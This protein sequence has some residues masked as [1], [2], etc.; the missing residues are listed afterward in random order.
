MPNI[1]P[2]DRSDAQV[3][4]GAIPEQMRSLEYQRLIMERG[5]LGKRAYML[6]M[7]EQQ[8][9]PVRLRLKRLI[10]DVIRAIKPPRHLASVTNFKE[11]NE[12]RSRK[13]NTGFR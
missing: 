4:V 9:V 8:G 11:S 13:A 12:S 2:K 5:N 3:T 1:S 7:L 6:N 10:V